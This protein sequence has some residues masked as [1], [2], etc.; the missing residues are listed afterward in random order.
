MSPPATPS[1]EDKPNLQ[2][3]RPPTGSF[4]GPAIQSLRRCIFAPPGAA[5][6]DRRSHFDPRTHGVW[7][8]HEPFGDDL[9]APASQP[10]ELK[11]GQS[12]FRGVVGPLVRTQPGPLVSQD[13]Q[14]ALRQIE[15]CMNLISLR[16]QAQR[17]R[18]HA[19][20]G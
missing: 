1:G 11:D 9:G 16:H 6:L 17:R 2:N 10:H 18:G 7:M 20:A 4:P 14:L 15:F 8:E 5:L 12:L 13:L 3:R 19:A